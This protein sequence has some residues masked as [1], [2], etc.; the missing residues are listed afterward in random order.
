[1]KLVAILFFLLPPSV[2]GA[3]FSNKDYIIQNKGINLQKSISPTPVPAL[4]P[5]E[6]LPA[7]FAFSLSDTVLDFGEVSAT[8]PVERTTVISIS[9]GISLFA[10]ENHEPTSL[11][12]AV[13]PDTLCDIGICTDRIISPWE[14]VLTY[15]FGYRLEYEDGYKQFANQVKDEFPT[16]IFESGKEEKSKSVKIFYKLNIPAT[17]EEGVYTNTIRYIAVPDF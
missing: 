17:Q 12:G 6:T 1:M 3:T 4:A 11:S 14:S 15:G 16:R 10:I 8:N 13:I 9:P 2:Y 5:T 7:P